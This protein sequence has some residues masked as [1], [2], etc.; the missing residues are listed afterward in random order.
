MGRL[1]SAADAA[2]VSVEQVAKNILTTL[3]P[4]K[5]G[6]DLAA[7]RVLKSAGDERRYTLGLAYGVDLPDVGK[8]ADG[9][10]DFVGAPALEDAAWSFIR[11]GAQVGVGHR[12]GTEGAGTV[13][14]SYIFRADPWHV[15]ATDGSE[16]IIMPGDWLV[17][18]VWSEETWPL[19]KGGLLRGFSPQGGAHRGKPTPEALARLR[20]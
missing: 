4:P 8:A 7:Y 14:E 1:L 16:Q 19:I 13:V 15:K 2:G 5:G 12:Q 17:G 18:V 10:R 6:T 9:F 11:K 3:M 20:R